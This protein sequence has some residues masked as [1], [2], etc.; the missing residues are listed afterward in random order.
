MNKQLQHRV[1][2]LLS[3]IEDDGGEMATDSV[4]VFHE[5][6][7]L[8][9]AGQLGYVNYVTYANGEHVCLTDAGNEAHEKALVAFHLEK[10]RIKSGEKAIADRLAKINLNTSF[11]VAASYRYFNIGLAEA[12]TQA[13]QAYLKTIEVVTH[14]QFNPDYDGEARCK[15]GHHY[16]RH[17][18]SY[19][20]MEAVGCKYC[21]CYDFE[22][23]ELPEGF[24]VQGY[25]KDGNP[26]NS[27]GQTPAEFMDT[28]A[29][30]QQHDEWLEQQKQ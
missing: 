27:L 11:P 16:Y 23:Q 20:E 12:V 22:P 17:F 7:T 24:D 29:L 25:T 6:E 19:E 21:P 28:Q 4:L 14:K 18:D 8:D 10:E 3:D 5:Q 9:L 13:G 1:E 2:A 26:F 30:A 15:C